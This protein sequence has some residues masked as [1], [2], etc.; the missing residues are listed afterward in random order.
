MAASI[1][2]FHGNGT[3]AIG[4]SGV[5]FFGATFGSSVQ[6]ASYQDTT[7]ITNGGGTVNGGS[8]INNKYPGNSSGVVIDGGSE[9]QLSGEPTNS[10]TLNIR[11]TFDS[12]VQ[13]QNEDFRIFDRTDIDAGPSGVTCKVAQLVYG[14]SGVDPTTGEAQAWNATDDG[15]RTLAGSGT[16]AHLLTSPGSGGLSP[17]G[18]GTTDTRHDWY[19]NLS[20]TPQSIG[21]KTLFGAYTSLEYL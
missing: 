20:A 21:S 8:L 19:M 5:G 1:D 18:T 17:N 4:A 2:F 13:T 16:T 12:A 6:V 7:F 9:V 3:T 11:F 10:G 14:G 15:W